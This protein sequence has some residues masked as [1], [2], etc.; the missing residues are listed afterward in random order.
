MGRSGRGLPRVVEHE[1]PARRLPVPDCHA[2]A[3]RIADTLGHAHR[4]A[5]DHRTPDDLRLAE[6]LRD[7]LGTERSRPGHPRP[8]EVT[9]RGRHL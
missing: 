1:R 3:H 7:R 4:I 6:P 8:W 5:D 9:Q 2:H